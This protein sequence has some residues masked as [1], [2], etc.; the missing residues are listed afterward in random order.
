MMVYSPSLAKSQRQELLKRL[1]QA[2]QEFYPLTQPPIDITLRFDT[3]NFLSPAAL[4]HGFL[5]TFVNRDVALWR[6]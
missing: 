1:R 4:S 3:K 6:C 5:G 2:Q